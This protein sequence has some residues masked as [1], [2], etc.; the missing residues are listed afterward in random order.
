VPAC[1]FENQTKISLNLSP[2]Y[3]DPLAG[4][5]FGLFY[6]PLSLLYAC[7]LVMQQ[8]KYSLPLIIFGSVSFI[9]F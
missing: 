8:V 1:A 9:N 6:L 2:V 5:A 7:S 4:N 3:E